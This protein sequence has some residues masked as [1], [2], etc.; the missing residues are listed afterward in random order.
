MTTETATT[1][2]TTRDTVRVLHSLAPP[3]GTTKYVD[4]MTE[5]APDDVEVSYFSWKRA[6]AGDYDVLH[7][8]WPEFLLRAK[9]GRTRFGKRQAMRATLLVTRVRRIPIVRTVHNLHPHERG[10][11]GERRLLAKIDRRTTT[12]IRLNPTTEVE[13]W[14]DAVTIL[15]GHYRDRFAEHPRE[16]REAGL[17]LYFGIIRP[18]KGVEKLI[19][20]FTSRDRPGQRLRIVGSPTPELSERIASLT[21]DT[22]DVTTRL[23]FVDDDEL[24]RE[25]SRASLVVLPYAEMHNSGAALVALSLDRPILVPRSASNSAL[26]AEAGPGWVIEYDGELTDA[27]LS[28]AL[29]SARTIDPSSRPRL[30]GRDWDEVGRRHRAVYRDAMIA[31]GSGRMRAR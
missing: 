27:A 2:G 7:L 8:H 18:Y 22:P 5:G 29:E 19:D 12:F 13:P 24:V 16:A 6:L 3:D 21:A 9:S 28:A 10:G 4:Q 11:R 26:S 25:I 20:V 1:S 14:M 31:A 23:A 15:H 30:D 17:V